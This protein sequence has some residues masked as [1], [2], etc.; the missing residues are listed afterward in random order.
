MTDPV[1]HYHGSNFLE[2]VD[3]AGTHFVRID[4][5]KYI[6][7][8]Y[9]QLVICTNTRAEALSF[10][11]LDKR[12]LQ[13]MAGNILALLSSPPPHI[14]DGLDAVKDAMYMVRKNQQDL[15][16]SLLRIT[17]K[18]DTVRQEFKEELDRSL[19]EQ[20][21]EE[22]EEEEELEVVPVVKTSPLGETFLFLLLLLLLGMGV[23]SAMIH[24]V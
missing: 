1:L 2:I 15:T 4:A 21:E 20:E 10:T 24:R 22:E 23:Q 13:D 8:N 9:T 11:F 5:I 12:R 6:R 7:A 3:T 16:E 19:E 14:K 17:E 18:L